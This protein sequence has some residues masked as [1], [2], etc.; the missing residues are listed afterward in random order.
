MPVLDKS[1]GLITHVSWA[2]LKCQ[3]CHH[4]HSL[5]KSQLSSS[6]YYIFSKEEKV[7]KVIFFILP[8]IDQNTFYCGD[9][10]LCYKRHTPLLQ[11]SIPP[12]LSQMI[13]LERW[14]HSLELINHISTFSMPS[15]IWQPGLCKEVDLTFR[16]VV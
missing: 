11:S 13:N 6:L 14:S 5:Y 8:D 9:E 10:L 15:L 4:P 2:S 16:K 7:V 3:L 12:P 1:S